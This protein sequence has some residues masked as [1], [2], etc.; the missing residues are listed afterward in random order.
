MTISG[1][2]SEIG[3]LL[4]IL[5][6]AIRRFRLSEVNRYNQRHIGY[7]IGRQ[8]FKQN[9]GQRKN[10]IDLQRIIINAQSQALAHCQKNRHFQVAQH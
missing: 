9:A 4:V 5:L 7:S 10:T 2:C 3:A 6:N 8:E 1:A